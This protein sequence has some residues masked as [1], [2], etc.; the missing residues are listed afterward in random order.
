MVAAITDV[1]FMLEDR[2]QLSFG[3]RTAQWKRPFMLFGIDDPVLARQH[4]ILNTP[5]VDHGLLRSK[6]DMDHVAPYAWK[7][8]MIYGTLAMP[9]P[10]EIRLTT[11]S[12]GGRTTI[13]ESL[14]TRDA[15]AAS[16]LMP[17]TDQR[18]I[19]VDSRGNVRG[20]EIVTPQPTLSLE[21]QAEADLII[22]DEDLLAD[23]TLMTGTTNV[24]QYRSFLPGELLFLGYTHDARVRLD[25][26]ANVITKMSFNFAV[27]PDQTRDPDAVP[28]AE[29]RD[30]P[31]R[32][33]QVV[34][35]DLPPIAKRGWDYLEVRH[36]DWEEEQTA[37]D[38]DEQEPEDVDDRI[39]A[40]PGDVLKTLTRRP[41]YAW[42]QQVYRETEFADFGF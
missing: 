40:T 29:D 26:D 39:T 24:T 22:G 42:T 9:V 4:L 32:Q 28:Y 12:T 18:M 5:A 13:T 11:S 37:P 17:I 16:G 31:G 21:F 19:G 1:Q 41:R 10:G 34:I 36:E 7:G 23:F 6:A 3:R 33:P 35:G 25:Q 20:V 30:I 38:P 27:S 14:L 2:E 8:N 15:V